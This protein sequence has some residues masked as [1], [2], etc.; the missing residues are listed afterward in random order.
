[1]TNVLT[2]PEEAIDWLKEIGAGPDESVDVAESSLA[3][4]VLFHPGISLDRYRQHFI[5]LADQVREACDNRRKEGEEDTAESRAACLKKVIHEDNGY[6]GDSETYDDIQNADMIRVIDRRKG[7]PVAIG[8]LYLSVARR[9]DWD[10]AGMSFPGHF[11]VRLEKDGQ[12]LILDP[13]RQGQELGAPELR[14][15][16]KSILGP[17]AELSHD[18]Y[19]VA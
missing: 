13:F 3:L 1:M 8:V 17:K 19:D 10:M 6:T 14:K 9:L 2:T 11:L 18:F 12:R 7:L 15:L 4:A 5:R 16:L